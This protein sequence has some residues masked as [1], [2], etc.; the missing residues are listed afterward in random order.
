MSYVKIIDP[1]E[2][3]VGTAEATALGIVDG[4]TTYSRPEFIGRYID[5][6][7]DNTKLP[8]IDPLTGGTYYTKPL[9]DDTITFSIALLNDQYIKI[10]TN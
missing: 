6:T 1:I 5:I 10:I 3:V 4:I 8:G 2:V 9:N 7:I